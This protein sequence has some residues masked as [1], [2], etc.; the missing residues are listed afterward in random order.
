[1][2][3]RF[4]NEV[5]QPFF[6]ETFPQRHTPLHLSP[7]LPLPIS[8]FFPPSLFLVLLLSSV[9]LSSLCEFEVWSSLIIFIVVVKR[10]KLNSRLKTLYK[11]PENWN[12]WVPNVRVL[13]LLPELSYPLLFAILLPWIEPWGGGQRRVY[14]LGLDLSEIPPT[15]PTH[16]KT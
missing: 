12:I 10:K 5:T 8:V 6:G 7:P 3:P 2:F 9:S 11:E 4:W 15:L 14:A 1:M 16:Y 13:R